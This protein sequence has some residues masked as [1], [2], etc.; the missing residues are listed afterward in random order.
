M[1][2][3]SHPLRHVDLEVDL[4]AV[5]LGDRERPVGAPFFLRSPGRRCLGTAVRDN[6]HDG[7]LG[8]LFTGAVSMYKRT[9]QHDKCRMVCTN[10]IDARSW[11]R[12]C[13]CLVPEHSRRMRLAPSVLRRESLRPQAAHWTCTARRNSTAIR[14]RLRDRDIAPGLRQALIT[15]YRAAEEPPSRG[16][17]PCATWVRMMATEPLDT[18]ASTSSASCTPFSGR[19]VSRT[20]DLKDPYARA[21]QPSTR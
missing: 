4:I 3:S 8:G 2:S 17:T 18:T 13:Y 21:P 9:L 19:G 6:R 11:Q 15:Q 12:D 20:A 5:H 10:F 16:E 14:H 1:F 7:L